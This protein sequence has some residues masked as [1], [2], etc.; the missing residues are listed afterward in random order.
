MKEDE[1]KLLDT[2]LKVQCDT[3]PKLTDIKKQKRRTNTVKKERE[4]AT[5]M[6]RHDLDELSCLVFVQLL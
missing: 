6:T 2:L 1:S 3:Y 4:V 5:L